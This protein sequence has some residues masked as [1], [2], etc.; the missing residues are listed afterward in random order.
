MPSVTKPVARALAYRWGEL[1]EQPPAFI[2]DLMVDLTR[3]LRDAQAAREAAR[4]ECLD[5]VIE[6]LAE[7]IVKYER[8][9]TEALDPET[10]ASATAEIRA[11]YYKESRKREA[12][13]GGEA[14][15]GR[16][17]VTRRESQNGGAVTSQLEFK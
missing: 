17:P 12:R 3:A 16:Q 8:E 11:Y 5:E 4:A 14:A 10:L 15:V 6:A 1:E 13:I 9:S 2:D 7:G